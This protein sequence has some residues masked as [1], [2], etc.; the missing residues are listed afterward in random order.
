MDLCS[1]FEEEEKADT[2]KK[3]EEDKKHIR[4]YEK[5]KQAGKL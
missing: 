1:E 3:R 2:I 5:K 4:E